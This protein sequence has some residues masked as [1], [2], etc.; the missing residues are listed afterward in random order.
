MQISGCGS[1][2][3]Y[4]LVPCLASDIGPGVQDYGPVRCKPVCP[5]PPYCFCPT[6]DLNMICG[7]ETLL[8]GHSCL[9]VR[10]VY[11]GQNHIQAGRRNSVSAYPQASPKGPCWLRV[12]VELCFG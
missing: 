5:S 7:P 2:E 8:V 12:C 11:L 4:K 6:W 10:A 1:P 3:I 9:V